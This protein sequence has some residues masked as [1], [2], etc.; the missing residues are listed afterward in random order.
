MRLCPTD[1]FIE[2]LTF[3]PPTSPL[4]TTLI[5]ISHNGMSHYQLHCEHGNGQIERST[6]PD[7]KKSTLTILSHPG[8]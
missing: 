8:D 1:N 6:L 7:P 4:L 2:L 5:V 3:P